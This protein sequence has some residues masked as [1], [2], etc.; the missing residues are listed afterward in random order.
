[1][2]PRLMKIIDKF[3]DKINGFLFIVVE[4]GLYIQN[5]CPAA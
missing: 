1:M 4:G 3:I 2:S 5:R